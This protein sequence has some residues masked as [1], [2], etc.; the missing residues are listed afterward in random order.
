M[1]PA[2]GYNAYLELIGGAIGVGA[3]AAVRR[4]NKIYTIADDVP[5][6]HFL[7]GQLVGRRW[8][9]GLQVTLTFSVDVTDEEQGN[10][11]LYTVIADIVAAHNAFIESLYAIVSSQE[12]C[13]LARLLPDEPTRVY[14]TEV[15]DNH[16]IVGQFKR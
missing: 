3:C 8:C 6:L 1:P 15:N 4:G 2:E 10:D 9:V 7:S 13:P 12:Q 14:T 11:W 5:L 16:C